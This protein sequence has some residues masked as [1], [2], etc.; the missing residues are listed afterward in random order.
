ML[1]DDASLDERVGE[2]QIHYQVLV[3]RKYQINAG[4]IFR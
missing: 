2:L 3:G 1:F 4:G